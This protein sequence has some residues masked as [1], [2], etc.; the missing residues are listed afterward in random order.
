MASST[1]VLM[2][3]VCVCV[4][5]CACVCVCVSPPLRLSITNSVMQCDSSMAIIWQLKSVSLV[6]MAMA[7]AS[8][9]NVEMLYK[10]LLHCT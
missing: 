4:C 3:S 6:G 5:V 8:I 9:C 1:N 2:R 10:P 7:L